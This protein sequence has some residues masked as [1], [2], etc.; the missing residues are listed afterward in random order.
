MGSVFH[1]TPLESQWVV[2]P[3]LMHG[4]Y[5]G[6]Q[7][8]RW[9]VARHRLIGEF[10]ARYGRRGESLATGAI[11]AVAYF[12]GLAVYDVHGITDVHIAHH[13]VAEGALGSGLPGHEKTDYPYVFARKPTFYM[14]SRKLRKKPLAGLP[15]LVDEV[16]ELVERE[17]RVGS[18]SLVDETNGQS[19][20]FS[21]LERR[22][23]DS[24]GL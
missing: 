24:A 2:K 23:R 17:Y 16:D 1:S 7:S 15:H 12:S 20:Y 21:F 19:G 13:G 11:G 10:F 6:I 3:E 5:R 14:F 4:N 18:V 22:D 9:Y 8:E